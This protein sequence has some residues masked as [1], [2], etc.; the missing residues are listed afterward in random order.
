[1]P[2][3]L[4]GDGRTAIVVVTGVDDASRAREALR[5]GADEYVVKPYSISQ[6]R[7][8][9]E[10]AFE[11]RRQFGEQKRAER[12]RDEL[13][14]LIFHDLRSPLTAARGYLSLMELDPAAIG[15]R[16]IAAAVQGCDLAVDIIEQGEDLGR[17]ERS[18]IGVKNEEL[19]LDEVVPAV[20]ERLRPLAASAGRRIRV[21]RARDLPAAVADASLVKRVAS[22]LLAG[23]IKY[24][25]SKGDILVELSAS[26][27]RS[28]VLLTVTDDGLPVPREFREAIFDKHSQGDLK[29]AGSRRGRGIALPFAREACRRMG[30]RVWVEDAEAADP[31][32]TN[33]GA[34]CRFVVAFRAA[35]TAD[36]AD[37]LPTNPSCPKGAVQHE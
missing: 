16:D 28:E 1:M 3:Y 27:D 21:A 24:A 12:T 20:V 30:A 34:G 6:L 10:Q 13:T 31:Q 37:V 26:G 15:P 4:A 35:S 29:R 9:W 8:A 17:I 32:A 7:L 25:S 18:E 23:A 2:V 36:V 22:A 14:E 33:E 5:L 11:R 19:R